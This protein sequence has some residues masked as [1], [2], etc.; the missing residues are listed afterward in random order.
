MS[1][2][3]WPGRLHGR[4]VWR[5]AFAAFDLLDEALFVTTEGRHT[6]R[7]LYL[8]VVGDAFSDDYQREE[9]ALEDVEQ[10]SLPCG[11][12]MPGCSWPRLG[13]VAGA[14]LLVRYLPYLCRAPS[15]SNAVRPFARGCAFE[16][17][18][19]RRLQRHSLRGASRVKTSS[20]KEFPEG[21]VDPE[22]ES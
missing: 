13:D 4:E 15:K 16:V 9:L 2:T 17:H 3:I 1:L 18:I 19:G 8:E 20:V 7:I 5:L 10:E 11:Q 22:I 6:V 14:R 21:A 12:A